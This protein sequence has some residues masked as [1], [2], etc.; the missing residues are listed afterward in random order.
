MPKFKVVDAATQKELLVGEFS[1]PRAAAVKTFQGS[2][3]V[4][5]GTY[6][7]EE[8]T[9]GI[10]KYKDVQRRVSVARV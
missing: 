8:G 5:V 2:E 10:G 9:F 4:I 7:E 1:D 3:K 6:D